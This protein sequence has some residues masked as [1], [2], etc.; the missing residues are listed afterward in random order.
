MAK[1]KTVRKTTRGLRVN[2]RLLLTEDCHKN[3]ENFLY[4]TILFD[5]IKFKA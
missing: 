5:K 4:V 3:F 1:T 2:Q